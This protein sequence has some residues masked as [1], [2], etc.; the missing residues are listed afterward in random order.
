MPVGYLANASTQY[1]YGVEFNTDAEYNGLAIDF[2]AMAE[3]LYQLYTAA[4]SHGVKI[5]LVIFDPPFLPKLFATP[6]GAFFQQNLPFMKASAC[7]RHD[8]HYHVD[9]T[10]PCKS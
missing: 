10:V 4:D 1:G 9:F 2:P 3:H 5:A 8:E 6:R 7:V